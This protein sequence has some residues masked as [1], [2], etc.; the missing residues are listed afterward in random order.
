MIEKIIFN[1]FAFTLF[2]LMFFKFIRKNDTSYV[3]L[4]IVQFIGILINFLELTFSIKL[5]VA[6]KLLI[7]VLSVIIPILVMRLEYAKK[8]QF[9]EVFYLNMANIC[10]FMRND[11][12]ARKYLE[13]LVKK[14]PN[15]VTGYK[16][17]A[18]LY[19]KHEK[20]LLALEQYENVYEID[21]EDMQAQIKIGNLYSSTGRQEEA[22]TMFYNL[23]KKN[24][25]LY[26]VSVTLGDILYNKQDYK[27]AI[28][29]YMSAL[30]YNPTDYD[31]YYNLGMTY[32]MLNDFQKAKDAYEKAAHINMSLHHAEYS[33]GQINLIYGELDEAEKYFMLVIEDEEL[34]DGAY[35]YLARIAL[36]RGEKDKAINYANI[37]IEEN[38]EVYKR[39]EEE[40]IFVPIRDFINKPE[41]IQES[42][43]KKNKRKKLTIKETQVE[44]YLYD[45]CNLVG[46][47][48]NNDI[49]MI[50]NLK[51]TKQEEKMQDSNENERENGEY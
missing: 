39:I 19:E 40:N 51:R 18:Q 20:Y 34:E 11:K 14:Y 15:N 3:Y 23:L 28:Q 50:E 2:I 46:K 8:I 9:P 17:L 49:E 31:L 42:D 24:P 30:R 33:L 47:L 5:N 26:E 1:L 22:I 48:N 6:I 10:I 4:L 16:K 27:E 21:K 29:V 13:M 44:E 7:Y 36:I 43:K 35:Y 45:T 32:T 41:N 37:A 25:S 38:Y 12:Q